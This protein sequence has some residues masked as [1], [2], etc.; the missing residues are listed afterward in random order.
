MP[1]G[2]SLVRRR[3]C[4]RGRN[5]R[6]QIRVG[7]HDVTYKVVVMGVSGSGKST[8]AQRLAQALNGTFIEGDDRGG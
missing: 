5:Q 7:R 2:A 4:E 3:P 1:V 6:V 8:L